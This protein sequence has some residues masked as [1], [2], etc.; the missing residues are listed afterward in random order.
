MTRRKLTPK[1]CEQCDKLIVRKKTDNRLRFCSRQCWRDNKE[2]HNER[3][4]LAGRKRGYVGVNTFSVAEYVRRWL[5]K[6][7]GNKCEKCGWAKVNPTTQRIPLE[8]NH[9]DGNFRNNN[10]ENLELLCP[11]CHS[12]TPNFKSLNRNGK[13]GRTIRMVTEA[14]LKTVEPK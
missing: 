13:P 10:T 14:V 12:L 6:R 11:S 1:K 7:A 3:E 5:F 9:V 2:E 8:A 4:W